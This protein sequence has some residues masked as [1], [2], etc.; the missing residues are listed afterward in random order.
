MQYDRSSAAQAPLQAVIPRKS[1]AD[2]NIAQLVR[3]AAQPNPSNVEAR[4]RAMS[5]A[6]TMYPEESYDLK[7]RK[8]TWRV[9]TRTRFPAS[10]FLE[11]ENTGDDPGSCAV[12]LREGTPKTLFL[13]PTRNR[14]LIERTAEL[15]SGKVIEQRPLVSRPPRSLTSENGL[16]YGLRLGVLIVFFLGL[17]VALDFFLLPRFG[18]D[19]AKGLNI[20]FSSHVEIEGYQSLIRAFL[21]K[22]FGPAIFPLITSI[23]SLAA[24][25]IVPILLIAVVFEFSGKRADKRRVKDLPEEAHTFYFGREAWEELFRQEAELEDERARQVLF[26]KCRA[27]EMKVSRREFSD[28]YDEMK[29]ILRA[30][31]P[32]MEDLET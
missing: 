26:E 13:G 6:P 30:L 31:P 20:G 4:E 12:Y 8:G 27:H 3:A 29:H 23:Y 10:H 15:L 1:M 5:L 14:T 2:K 28:L 24:L 21:H 25:I 19:V 17:L 32:K 9:F 16:S 22:A 7:T 11:D 18:S